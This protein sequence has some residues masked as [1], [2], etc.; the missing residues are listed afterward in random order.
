MKILQMPSRYED[1][2]A[3]PIGVALWL[4]YR[5]SNPSAPK[6]PPEG[7]N[8]YTEPRMAAY[9]AHVSSCDH[10]NEGLG[11]TLRD[12][13]I[14]LMEPPINRDYSSPFVSLGS[15]VNLEAVV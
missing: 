7:L 1:P 13:V 3:C 15:E 2:F 12:M 10:C 11:S 5:R 4:G 14:Q 8:D 6:M 9:V